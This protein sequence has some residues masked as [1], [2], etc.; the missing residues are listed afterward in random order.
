MIRKRLQSF[1][2]IL[3]ITVLLVLAAVVA[4]GLALGA[5]RADAAGG[6]VTMNGTSGKPKKAKLKKNGKA[7]PPSNA[8][9]RVVKAIEAGNEIRRKPYK[10]GG[11]HRRWNDRGY[12]CSGAVSYVLHG[13]K[14]LDSPLDS[15]D[16]M[17]WRKKGKGKWITVYAH[18]GHTFIEVAG[19]RFDT[20]DTGGKG[21][22]W[23][24]DSRS[25]RGFKARRYSKRI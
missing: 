16:L 7:I 3:A 14:M 25:K 22:R 13:G 4:L 1:D 10:W 2:P 18:G 21:P 20:S 17:R 5:T 15:G 24:K 12:D 9:K 6:G 19:L 8:P 23:H 11:G